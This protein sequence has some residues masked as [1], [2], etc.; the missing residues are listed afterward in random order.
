[1]TLAE[2]FKD[3]S[4][5]KFCTG[6]LAVDENGTDWLETGSES[7]K[8]CAT[9]WVLTKTLKTESDELRELDAY[10]MSLGY[11]DAVDANDTMGYDFIKSI[12]ENCK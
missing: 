8:W 2:L 11:S 3:L 6:H 1:M 5:D 7:K 10:A 12:Q 9:G 4:E